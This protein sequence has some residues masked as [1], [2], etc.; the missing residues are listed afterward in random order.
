[1]TDVSLWWGRIK[2]MN[3]K[4]SEAFCIVFVLFCDN[5]TVLETPHNLLHLCNIHYSLREWRALWPFRQPGELQNLLPLPAS[6]SESQKFTFHS[7]Q[8]LTLTTPSFPP[9]ALQVN[10]SWRYLNSSTSHPPFPLSLQ[11]MFV[12]Q[13]GVE[14]IVGFR[15]KSSRAH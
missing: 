12:K 15:E 2:L 9:R 3:S 13:W 6:V 14:G 8:W 10:S 11:H 1:M 5:L 4:V 7:E